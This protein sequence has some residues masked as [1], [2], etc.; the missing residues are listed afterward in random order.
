MAQEHYDI[1]VV[2]AGPAGLSAA[3]TLARLGFETAVVERAAGPGDLN[4]VCDGIVVPA[5]GLAPEE[6]MGGG[7]YFPQVDLL[8]P[9][10]LVIARKSAQRF[11]APGGAAFDT[12]FN[13]DGTTAVM[14]NKPGLLRMLAWQAE[15]A[16]AHFMWET[17]ALG[18]LYEDGRVAGVRTPGGDITANLVISAEGAIRHLCEQADL[19]PREP[20]P[21]QH[22]LVVS[23][24][25]DA[26]MVGLGDLGRIITLGRAYTSAQNGLGVLVMSAPG[27]ATMTFTIFVDEIDCATVSQAWT[28]LGEYASDPRISGLLAGGCV[29]RRS[30]FLIPIGDAP[31]NVVRD[32]FMAVGDAISPAGYTGILPAIYQGRQAALI[33]AEALE[34]GDVSA[35]ALAPFDDF[36]RSVTLPGLQAELRATRALLALHDYEVDRLCQALNWL[37]LPFPF[38]LSNPYVTNE[39]AS[40]LGRQFALDPED[41]ALVARVFEQA[42]PSLP[43]ATLVPFWEASNEMAEA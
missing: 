9:E 10:S 30:S 18:L 3:R 28:Y 21:A 35:A 4:H 38:L 2:G 42:H 29:L 31:D 7:L 33:A 32:H 16:G 17:T 14:I 39:T 19:Y 1:V 20:R 26:P 8:I 5:S 34:G 41:G 43:A 37:H 24:E 12:L 11:V 22:A 6:A 25:L 36:F 13:Q 27:R 40:W 15:A 23:Q